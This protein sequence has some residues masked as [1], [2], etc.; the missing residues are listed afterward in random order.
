M[1]RGMLPLHSHVCTLNSTNNCS[2][3]TQVQSVK[4]F[5]YQNIGGCSCTELTLSIRIDCY[6]HLRDAGLAGVV[7]TLSPM[8]DWPL[9]S[10]MIL[11]CWCTGS[12]L[13]VEGSTLTSGLTLTTVGVGGVSGSS[14]FFFVTSSSCL[15]SDREIGWC[16]KI[17]SSEE[18]KSRK[19]S[20]FN[21]PSFWLE[22]YAYRSIQKLP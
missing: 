13:D 16:T 14:F 10:L 9:F 3:N 21:Q 2:I 22:K 4:M 1:A 15:R 18:I 12:W 17:S 20:I 5:K 7:I 8:C 19:R 6:S 11:F